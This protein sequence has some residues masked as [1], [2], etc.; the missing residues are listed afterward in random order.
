MDAIDRNFLG[1]MDSNRSLACD[2]F[3]SP[4]YFLLIKF[5]TESKVKLMGEHRITPS[6]TQISPALRLLQR[7]FSDALVRI[8]KVL[9]FCG[10]QS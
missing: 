10:G 3:T 7:K 2:D 8:Q 6:S 9:L 4:D 1:R 5:F